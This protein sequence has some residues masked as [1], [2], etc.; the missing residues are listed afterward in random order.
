MRAARELWTQLFA[1][2]GA[3]DATEYWQTDPGY[4][5][6]DG[7][8]YSYH[9]AGHNVGTHRM[10]GKPEDSV[11]DSDQRCWDHENLYLIGC[12]SLPTIATSNPSLTMAALAVR[13][14]GSLRDDLGL[15]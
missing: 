13:S 14:V 10:G 4:L 7:Q 12:G 5:S 8:P 11:V 9:G 2:L 15:R 1:Y 3:S 6:Y